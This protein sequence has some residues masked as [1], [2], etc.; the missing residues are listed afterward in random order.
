MIDKYKSID[1]IKL[2]PIMVGT[3]KD[4]KQEINKLKK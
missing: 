1:Y 4:L 3:I 2:I